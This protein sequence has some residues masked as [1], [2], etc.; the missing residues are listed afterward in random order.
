MARV[1]SADAIYYDGNKAM[2]GKDI[3]NEFKTEDTLFTIGISGKTWKAFNKVA[4]VK[5][6][7][8]A[9]ELQKALLEYLQK[10]EDAL[11]DIGT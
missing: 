3:N 6:T 5:G 8:V 7:G 1:K 4:K 2:V 11:E 9:D 10:N